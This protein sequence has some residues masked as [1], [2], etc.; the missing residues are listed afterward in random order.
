ME[1]IRVLNAKYI[2]GYKIEFKFNDGTIKVID[3]QN[4]L[5]GEVF[6]PLNNIE[7]FRNFKLNQFTIEWR[8]RSRFC[9]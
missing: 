3:L 1:L 8:K 4:E 9:T 5:Y 2:E 7:K 6:E